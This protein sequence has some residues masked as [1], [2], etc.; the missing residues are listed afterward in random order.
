MLRPLS[1]H[2]FDA[3]ASP[4]SDPSDEND[5]LA[6][7]AIDSDP[8]TAWHTQYYL[9]DP[10]FGGL[11]KGTGLIL[12]M[13]SRVRLSSVTLSLG[14][15]SGADVAIE[16][17]ND[18]TLAA[19]TLRTFHTTARA[20]DIGWTYTFKTARQAEGRYVLIWFTKLP[21]VGPGR[22]EAQIFNIIIRGWRP[23]RCPAGRSMKD[24][25]CADRSLSTV[26]RR[27]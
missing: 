9:R 7:Y 2:G 15:A 1:A 10:V 25:A 5:A 18:D 21:A 14:P 26:P 12:D 3:L 27:T 16:I 11:K 22:F 6:A 20:N 8:N 24:Y 17:G 13:G 23:D 4:G 19:V